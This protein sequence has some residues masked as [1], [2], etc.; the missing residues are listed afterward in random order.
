MLYQL[1]LALSLIWFAH[2]D[3]QPPRPS[4]CKVNRDQCIGHHGMDHVHS[5]PYIKCIVPI[6]REQE[7]MV[8][9][10][11]N[12]VNIEQIKLINI[13]TW[14]V[15]PSSPLWTKGWTW[16]TY[17]Y[18]EMGEMRISSNSIQDRVYILFPNMQLQT[19]PVRPRIPSGVEMRTG[20]PKK[21]V[22]AIK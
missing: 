6:V 3:T 4:T 8:N 19:P 10:E 11:I 9:S 12:A 7:W 18:K 15:S 16:W 22:D 17:G 21:V 1:W 2:T 13:P 14:T 20:H 5:T